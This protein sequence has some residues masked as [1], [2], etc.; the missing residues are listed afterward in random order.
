MRSERGGSVLGRAIAHHHPHPGEGDARLVPQR[1]GLRRR[2][3]HQPPHRRQIGGGEPRLLLDDPGDHRRHRSQRGA[4]EAGGRV[5]IGLRSK[6]GEQDQRTPAHQGGL[7]HG[8]RVHVIQRGGGEKS[9]R[10]GLGKA[11][12]PG[13][14][15]PELSRMPQ[16]HAFRPAGR[17]RGVEDH[18]YFARLRRYPRERCRGRILDRD[19]VERGAGEARRQRGGTL[20]IGKGE[21]GGGI[22]QD[23]RDRRVGQL[24]IDRH[25]DQSGAHDREIGDEVLGRVGAEHGD[26]RAAAQ[27]PA[28]E[29][30]DEREDRA[31]QRTIAEGAGPA[32]EADRDQRG[33]VGC[34]IGV[35]QIAEIDRVEAHGVTTTLPNTA[36]SSKRL[37][38]ARPSLNGSTRS[39]TGTRRREAASCIRLS[40]SPRAQAFEPRIF[41][42][43]LQI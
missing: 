27:T 6:P 29:I 16:Q 40:R 22:L 36:R 24:G 5:N 21:F 41:N 32:V 38:A 31:V 15:R 1:L 17:A 11:S 25:R 20:A 4:A 18:R 43:K 13:P 34:A 2:A 3:H 28:G 14:H 8:Q 12:E 23:E 42:S 26:A 37:T 10:L 9:L 19:R 30:G 7:G 33:L 39:I 35:E